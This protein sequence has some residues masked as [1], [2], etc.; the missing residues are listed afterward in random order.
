[1]KRECRSIT[2]TG[3][4]VSSLQENFSSGRGGGTVAIAF[5]YAKIMLTTG[6][7]KTAGSTTT[8]YDLTTN[9]TSM[10]GAPTPTPTPGG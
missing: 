7:G 8:S 9:T 6:D 2:L 4:G 10:S 1:M 5:D 3:V